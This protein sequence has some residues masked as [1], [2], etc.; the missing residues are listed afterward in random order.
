MSTS[1]WS[2]VLQI[3]RNRLLTFTPASGSTLATLLGSTSSGSGSDGKLFV[4]Q[5]PD[6]LTGAWGIIRIID[7]PQQ[8]FDG[9]FM[10]RATAELMLYQQGRRNQAAVERMADVATQAWLDWIYSENGAVIASERVASRFTVPYEEPADR[11]LVAVRLLLP[12]RCVPQFL[13]QYA[14]SG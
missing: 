4:G 10:I 8:G 13:L 7:A 5:A 9:G 1:S 6:N 12:F 3:V 11:E 14:E 2:G